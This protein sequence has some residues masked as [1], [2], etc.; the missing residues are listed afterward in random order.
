[1]TLLRGSTTNEIE[2]P[3]ERCWALV[4]DLEHAADW[5]RTLTSVAVIERDEQGRVAVFDTEI[6]VKVKRISVRLRASYEAPHRMRFSLLQSDDLQALEGGWEL[7]AEGP[8]RTRV[9]Y[10]LAVDPG[11]VGFLARPLE[12]A[13]RPLVMGHQPRELADALAEGRDS[14]PGAGASV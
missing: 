5:Q 6:D 9:T 13:I 10:E 14:A 11:Q 7:Q 1:M 4:A 12:R 8:G 2:F 3:L